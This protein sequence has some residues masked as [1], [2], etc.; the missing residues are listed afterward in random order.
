M[1]EGCSRGDYVRTKCSAF[2]VTAFTSKE[3][4]APQSKPSNLTLYVL[5]ML[6]IQYQELFFRK[7]FN[8]ELF[9]RESRR[10]CSSF[11]FTNSVMHHLHYLFALK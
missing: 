11:F 5:C 10:F 1:V 6:T 7:N 3:I 8:L 9:Y 2:F 4:D